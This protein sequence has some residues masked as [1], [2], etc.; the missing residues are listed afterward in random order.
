MLVLCEALNDKCTVENWELKLL[1]SDERISALGMWRTRF[2]QN[3]GFGGGYSTAVFSQ[4]GRALLHPRSERN[5][6]KPY[7]GACVN[8]NQL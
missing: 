8:D 1:K 7:F 2:D 4:T 6:A 3:S 5:K